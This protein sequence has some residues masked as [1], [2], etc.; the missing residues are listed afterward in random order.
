MSFLGGVREQTFGSNAPPTGTLFFPDNM[1]A[2]SAH[3]HQSCGVPFD[4][5]IDAAVTCDGT[6][7]KRGFTAMYGVVAVFL[8]KLDKY[9]T[10][11]SNPSVA[12]ADI[13]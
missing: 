7:S 1:V 11:R 4:E 5:I 8:G 13:K 2:A 3:L 9:W 6:W 12:V 10:L